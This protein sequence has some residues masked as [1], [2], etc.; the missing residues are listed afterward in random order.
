MAPESEPSRTAGSL[1]R[2]DT[3]RGGLRS[4]R[5]PESPCLWRASAQQS[6]RGLGEAPADRYRGVRREIPLHEADAIALVEVVRK[7]ARLADTIPDPIE[8]PP[9]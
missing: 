3:D 2:A 6:L 5:R 4:R 9:R 7:G 1:I 8:V